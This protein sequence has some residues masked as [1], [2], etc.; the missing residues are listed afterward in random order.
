MFVRKQKHIVFH[1]SEINKGNGFSEVSI[2]LFACV[3]VCVCVCQSWCAFAREREKEE[4]R[5]EKE[6][7]KD[8]EREGE[9]ERHR[10]SDYVRVCI[11]W[12]V[13]ERELER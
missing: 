5:G 10:E 11:D 9:R 12:N 3:R 6:K 8:R 4:E 2:W 1:T 13:W 7:E